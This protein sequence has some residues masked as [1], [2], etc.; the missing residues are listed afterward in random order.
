MHVLP[1][2]GYRL[3][4]CFGILTGKRGIFVRRRQK[5]RRGFFRVGDVGRRPEG[6]R[7][8]TFGLD[9]QSELEER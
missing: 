9:I 6:R 8:P 5:M 2:P 3:S 4:P 1:V 7:M